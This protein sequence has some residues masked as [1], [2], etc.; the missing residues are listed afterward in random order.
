MAAADGRIARLASHIQNRPTAPAPSPGSVVSGASTQGYVLRH[1]DQVVPY[2]GHESALIWPIFRGVDGKPDGG[3]ANTVMNGMTGWT[4]HRVQGRRDGDYHAHRDAEQLYYFLTPARMLIDGATISVVPGDLLHVPPR[5][6]HQLL[7]AHSEDWVEHL[8]VT[9]PVSAAMLAELDATPGVFKEQLVRNYRDASPTVVAHPGTR[10]GGSHGAH[11]HHCALEWDL[12]HGHRAHPGTPPGP[13]PL[14]GYAGGVEPALAEPGH[15]PINPP[16][17][18]LLGLTAAKLQ[19]LQP[20]QD[21]ENTPPSPDR[22]HIYFITQGEGV[23]AVDGVAVDVR[24]G[25]SL[26]LPRTIYIYIYIYTYIYIYI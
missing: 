11:A 12:F 13:T 5:V 16:P 8:L 26:Y 10:N 1:W 18:T 6:K 3:W 7:N 22:E 23:V 24:Q 14:G 20:H 25:D 17:A 2:V 19:R 15:E 4:I 9:A 21:S